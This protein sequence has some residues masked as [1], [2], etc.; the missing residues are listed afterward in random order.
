MLVKAYLKNTP[1]ALTFAENGRRAVDQFSEE[2]FDL[3]LM[4][5]F[6]PVMDGLAA[7]RAI[8]AMESEQGRPRVP[9]IA[10]TANAMAQDAEASRAAGCDAHLSKPVSRQ[11]LLS[12]I[13][14][15]GHP[16]TGDPS[17][18][19]LAPEIAEE[20]K[21]LIPE[22]LA[23]RFAEVPV[24]DRLLEASEFDGIRGIAHDL[25]GTGSAFGFPELTRLGREMEGSAKQS[26]GED[27]A[28]QL[29]ELGDYLARVRQTVN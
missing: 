17:V 12:T 21:A 28:R 29:R 25:K 18:S 3:V 20:L 1:H 6:M 5:M 16:I 9:V 7:T 26:S 15:Y 4:D 27:V 19:A 8:R 24:L 23:A 2:P 22:Y 11:K 13:Q 14:R 10:L